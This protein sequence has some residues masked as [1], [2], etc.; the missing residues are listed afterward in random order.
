MWERACVNAKLG[1]GTFWKHPE[2][3]NYKI[4][5]SSI[6]RGWLEAKRTLFEGVSF[7]PIHSRDRSHDKGSFP[8]AKPLYS[9]ATRTNTL[10]TDFATRSK[11]EV[12]PLLTIRDLAIWYLDDG[13]V[14]RR[15]DTGSY[16]F[17]LC[18]GNVLGCEEELLLALRRC[19]GLD[20]VG[21]LRKNNSKASPR[22]K[23]VVLTQ[24]AALSILEEARPFTPPELRYK[25]DL[26]GSTTIRKE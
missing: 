14:I 23:S 17:F 7:A 13:C 6:H 19:V 20:H 1:D 9:M 24:K 15:N 3:V 25:V 5:W 12:L 10:V 4:V 26:L 22:N 11:A 8:N 2:C 21:V 18:V 16:R